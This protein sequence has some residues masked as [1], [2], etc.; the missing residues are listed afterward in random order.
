MV[1]PAIGGMKKMEGDSVGVYKY[2][3]VQSSRIGERTRIWQ[4]C[5]ILSGAKIGA[6]CNI[7]SHCFIENDV[8]IGDRVTVKCGVQVWD[9]ITIED[10]VFIGPNVTFTNDPYPRSRQYPEMF[11]R[12]LVKRGA[13]IGANATILPGVTI[14]QGAMVGAGSVVTAGVPSNA[15]VVGNPA[16]VISYVNSAELTSTDTTKF[17][18]SLN[19][20]IAGLECLTLTKA[21]DLRGELTVAQ[22]NQ[23]LPFVPKRVFFVHNVPSTSVRGE[24]AHKECVQVLVALIGSLVV[25]LDDGK[26]RE[27]YVLNNS[28]NGLVIPAGVWASQ[29]RY[30]QDAV[31]A[32]F[33]SHDYDESDYIRNYDEFLEYCRK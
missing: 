16:R 18:S 11:S 13:S 33:A 14:G 21:K 26:S 4:F 9:G 22:W 27:E 23:H 2:S 12:T 20:R 24:H 32:V 6:D 10:D 5:V 30:S 1:Q 3:D 31:L 29:Y 28:S 8:I 19:S 7:C 17:N 25:V 15:V